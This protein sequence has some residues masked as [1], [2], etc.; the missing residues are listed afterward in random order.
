MNPAV[1]GRSYEMT[2]ANI[3]K[4]TTTAGSNRHVNDLRLPWKGQLVDVEAKRTIRAEFGQ[5]RAE[6]VDGL[7]SV[8]HPLF[9][10]CLAHAELF[11]GRIPPF[12][13]RRGITFPEWDMVS[14]SFADEQYHAPSDIISRYYASK[15]NHYIQ[16]NG[17]G[18]YH[19]GNDICGFG[20]PYFQCPS[21]VRVRCKRHGKKCPLTG[22]DI[23]TS[24]MASFWVK[25]PPAASPYSLDDPAKFPPGLA[26][27]LES[28][29]TPL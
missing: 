20:V 26:E 21:W 28:R 23:P 8:P 12:L 10:E 18:L 4:L 6:V 9:Q 7:L 5:R 11:E 3:L 29:S 1:V 22:K 19:T 16:V 15:Q 2:V 14:L 13:L 27:E 17:Y 25:T 24:V